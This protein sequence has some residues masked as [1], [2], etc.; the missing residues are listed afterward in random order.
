MVKK[1]KKKKLNKAQK[2]SLT[3]HLFLSTVTVAG[4][5]AYCG[6]LRSFGF[7]QGLLSGGLLLREKTLLMNRGAAKVNFSEIH[8]NKKQ[9]FSYVITEVSSTFYYSTIIM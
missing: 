2:H 6:R 3:L 4:F 9:W 7:G 5:V 8:H 1:R